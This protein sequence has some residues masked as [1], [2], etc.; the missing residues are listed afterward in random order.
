MRPL[1]FVDVETTGLDLTRHEILEI[2]VVVADPR[3]L[4]TREML[5]VRVRPQRIEDAD[6]AALAINGWCPEAWADAVPLDVALDRIKP[7]LDGALIAGHNVAFDRSFL[8]AA[9]RATCVAPPESDHHALDTATLAWPLLAVGLVDSLSLGPVCKQFGIDVGEPHRALADAR[10][11]LEVARC[12]LPEAGLITRVRALEA[13]ERALVETIL[14]RIDAGRADYGPWNTDDGRDYPREALAEVLDALNYCA[15]E[16][17]RI[18]RAARSADLRT[19]R[20]YVCHPFAD[21]PDANT[22]R[23]LDLCR[24][25]TDSG[26]LPIAP[27]IYLPRF[28]DEAT[29]RERALSLCL[30]LVGT[31][32]EVRVY[33]GRI[34]AGMRRE[35]EYAEAR[36]IPVRMVATEAAA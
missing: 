25:L 32:D 21:D 1:A 12:L 17:V 24:A 15:A 36:A 27:Q 6:P 30:E 16:L 35:I 28:M 22:K 9:W 4:E 19:R 10:R 8:D 20:V 7:L 23:V 31:C 13:D 29:E 11:S 3:T 2:G 34:T 18:G 14:A 26:Y 5:D 33:G